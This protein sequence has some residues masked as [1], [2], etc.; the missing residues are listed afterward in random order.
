MALRAD[1]PRPRMN[2]PL[3]RS[4]GSMAFSAFSDSGLETLRTLRQ[5]DGTEGG[6]IRSVDELS[7]DALSGLND[8]QCIQ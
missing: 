6:R 5:D 2:S 3:T 8:V 1:A 7:A 4:V